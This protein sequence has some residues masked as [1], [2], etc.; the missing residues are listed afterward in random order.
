MV[1]NLLADGTV[2]F[3]SR[4][5]DDTLLLIKPENVKTVLKKFNSF[6]SSLNFTCDQF[7]DEVHFLDIKIDRNKTDIYRKDTHTGQYVHFI[8]FE[9]WYR[10]TAWAKCLIER[11][12]RICSNKQLLDGQISKIKSFMS[13]NGY[14]RYVRNN[15][16]RKLKE[17]KKIYPNKVL[18]PRLR[19]LRRS[20]LECPTLDQLE[21][22]LPNNA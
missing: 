19:I 5:V 17:R 22:N 2:A 3:Y 14:P 4:Y 20:G 15:I 13:W 8:S 1:R 9:P 11:A 6:H 10:K 7:Q 16:I 21:K 12:E 18:L